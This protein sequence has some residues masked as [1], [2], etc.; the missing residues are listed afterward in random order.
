[1]NGSQDG[2]SRHSD[3]EI[4]LHFFYY[5][6]NPHQIWCEC[7]DSDIERICDVEIYMHIDHREFKMAAAIILDF[8]KW[9]RILNRPMNPHQICREGCDSNY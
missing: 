8:E 5:P 7:C 6:T 4:M 9:L 1:M 2:G 3:F